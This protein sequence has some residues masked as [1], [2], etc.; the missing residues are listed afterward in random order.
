MTECTS[1]LS[2]NGKHPQRP[3]K[4]YNTYAESLREK[5]ISSL[6]QQGFDV[7][8]AGIQAPDQTDKELLRKLHSV[9][10]EHRVKR[11]SALR[12]KEPTLIKRIA[13]GNEVD[14][15]RVTPRLVEVMPDS[16]DE[17]LFR[18]AALHW[19]IPVSSGYGRRIRF[20]VLDGQNDKL[21]GIIGLG[22][23]VFGLGARDQWIGWN[24]A[25]RKKPIASRPR[26]VCARRCAAI[27]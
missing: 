2:V 4:E 19:S 15:E 24:A 20:L 16:E 9:A 18:Y 11:G 3:G 8:E 14:P 13:E 25:Q 6:V 10:V 23:P 27:Q 12:P 17:L 22:D 7:T 1:E 26:R 5:I 21:I